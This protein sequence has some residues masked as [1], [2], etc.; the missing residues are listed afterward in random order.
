M[1]ITTALWQFLLTN[2]G[3]PFG[4]YF[5]MDSYEELEQAEAFS[6]YLNTVAYWI[7]HHRY[8]TVYFKH[9]L[10]C[11]GHF[12]TKMAHTKFCSKNHLKSHSKMIKRG[13][14][15]RAPISGVYGVSFRKDLGMSG[16]F[17]SYV[18]ENR[19]RVDVYLGDDFF[20]ACCARK[21]AE[22]KLLKGLPVK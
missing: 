11:S 8:C 15:R 3:S 20:E 12:A 22:A 1:K 21:S 10:W 13:G 6:S 4:G 5:I 16:R 2:G 19:K 18:K 17:V 9:C 14:S 7:R